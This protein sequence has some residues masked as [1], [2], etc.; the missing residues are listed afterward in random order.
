MNERRIMSPKRLFF[1]AAIVLACAQAPGAVAQGNPSNVPSTQIKLGPDTNATL[2]V[3]R[4]TGTVELDARV[5]RIESTF[6]TGEI[7]ND[8]ILVV[9]D[10]GSGLFWWEFQ[11][12]DPKLPEFK[13]DQV[14]FLLSR[15]KFIVQEEKI[16]GFRLPW[17]SLL[18]VQESRN[19]ALDFAAVQESILVSMRGLKN[20]YGDPIGKRNEISLVHVF[21]PTFFLGKI[22]TAQGRPSRLMSVSRISDGWEVDLEGPD[23]EKASV[24]LS[25][26]YD[27]VAATREGISVFPKSNEKDT[28]TP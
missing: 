28:K 7:R 1:L 11:R 2:E 24:T 6:P 18:W 3:A 14:A 5:L 12:Y 21:E 20:F 9:R 16:V 17:Q 26:S 4:G 8:L 22:Y 25:D 23:G 13:S 15:Y 19:K 27:V 10:V